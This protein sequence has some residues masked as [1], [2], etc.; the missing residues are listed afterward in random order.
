MIKKTKNNREI[1]T[2]EKGKMKNYEIDRSKW[3]KKKRLK[4]L[5]KKK[6]DQK[7]TTERNKKIKTKGKINAN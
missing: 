3:Q 5:R 4:N 6:I 2:A 7:L 1:R